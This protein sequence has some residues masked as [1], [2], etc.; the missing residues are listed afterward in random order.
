M[1]R[2]NDAMPDGEVFHSDRAYPLFVLPCIVEILACLYVK[3]ERQN[4]PHL[5]IIHQVVAKC[6]IPALI[7]PEHDEP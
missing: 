1:P 6:K 5:A 4:P 2:S 3:A 7:L